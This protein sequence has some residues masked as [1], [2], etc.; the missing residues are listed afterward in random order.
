[1]I[2]LCLN[3]KIIAVLRRHR[4]ILLLWLAKATLPLLLPIGAWLALYFFS[5]EAVSSIFFANLFWYF[6]SL[7]LIFCWLWGVL[8]WFKWYSDFWVLT[9]MRLAD[10]NQNGLFHQEILTCSLDQVENVTTSIRGPVQTFFKYGDV[11]IKTADE[12]SKITF[13][14]I[15]LPNSIQ[16]KILQAHQTY[17]QNIE[18]LPQSQVEKAA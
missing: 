13:E 1:M 15:P 14:K 4:L 5:Q 3:E 18:H 11:V 16:E 2:T 6:A 12:T 10:I 7:I 9:D 17:L 8:I